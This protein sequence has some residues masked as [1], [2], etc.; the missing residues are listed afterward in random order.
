M[1]SFVNGARPLERVLRLSLSKNSIPC[2]ARRVRM[3]ACFVS[4]D[5]TYQAHSKALLEGFELCIDRY[6]AYCNV[7]DYKLCSDKAER[8]SDCCVWLFATRW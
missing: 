1:L 2:R 3:M 4:F 7:S 6:V 8:L 5:T